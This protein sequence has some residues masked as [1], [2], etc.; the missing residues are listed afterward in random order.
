MKTIIIAAILMLFSVGMKSQ[1]LHI[2]GE[3]QSVED[4]QPVE[5]ANVVLQTLDSVFIAGTNSNEKGTFRL[6][7]IKPGDYQIVIS[8]LGYET[9]YVAV[10]G[11]T[12]SIDLGKI[13]LQPLLWKK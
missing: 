8:Y 10:L 13:Q 3:I 11:V 9:A 5:F 2:K 6:E 7:K 1:Q 12:K 4:S